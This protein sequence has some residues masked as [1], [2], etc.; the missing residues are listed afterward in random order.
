ME[1][2]LFS[3]CLAPMQHR[4]FKHKYIHKR[5]VITAA[6]PLPQRA[7]IYMGTPS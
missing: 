5:L 6:I 2:E 4:L 3:H 1:A 7:G